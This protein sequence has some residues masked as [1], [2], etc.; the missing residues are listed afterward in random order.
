MDALLAS[1]E[2]EADAE[3]ERLRSDARARA[4]ALTAQAGERVT[5]RREATLGR[6]EAE[7]R[8]ALERALA[9]ARHEAR[10]QVLQARDALLERLFGELRAALPAIIET[11]AYRAALPA[12]FAQT[13]AFAG[14]Q[15]VIVR[16]APALAPLLRPLAKSHGGLTI[17][18]DPELGAGFRIATTDGVLEVDGTLEGRAERLRPRLALEGLAALGAGAEVAA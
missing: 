16:C 4:A 2:R 3:I 7:G 18:P 6:R 1:L 12:A 9:G 11:P 5:R 15:A 14:D 17:H 8:A 10:G 13:L